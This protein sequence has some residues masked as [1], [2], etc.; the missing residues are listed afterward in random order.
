M[1]R[2]SSLPLVLEVPPARRVQAGAVLFVIATMLSVFLAPIQ[3]WP[4]QLL[5]VAVTAI[6]AW[7]PLRAIVFRR[8]RAAVQ[9][10]EW[11]AKGSWHVIDASGVRQSVRLS[12]RTAGI[13]PWLLLV[14][15]GRPTRYAL[16]DA[17]EVSPNAFRALRGR[18]NL[19]NETQGGPRRA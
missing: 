3:G 8:G 9:R 7:H 12:A 1:S 18:L 4:L 14:W 2:A 13:G 10:C 19:L 6:L 11:D 16:I 15:E 5:S 17:A